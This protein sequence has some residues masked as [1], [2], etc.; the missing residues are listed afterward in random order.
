M[1]FYKLI[2]LVCRSK[3]FNKLSKGLII[4]DPHIRIVK[5]IDVDFNNQNN[6]MIENQ[7]NINEIDGFLTDNFV[8]EIVVANYSKNTS[9]EIYN[10][11][12]NLN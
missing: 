2:L 11:L 8:S 7:L 1:R 12:L 5:F 10:K 9:I 3:D 6:L 4:N